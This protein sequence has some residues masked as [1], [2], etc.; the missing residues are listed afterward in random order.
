MIADRMYRG[1]IINN[2]IVVV[3]QPA[4][5]FIESCRFHSAIVG[6]EKGN[7]LKLNQF[8]VTGPD[9]QVTPGISCESEGG[10]LF[11]RQKL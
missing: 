6:T 5:I 4:L 8:S 7:F 3:N 10:N 11:R 1:P 9:P 2:S